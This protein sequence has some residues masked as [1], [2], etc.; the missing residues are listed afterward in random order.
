VPVRALQLEE[1]DYEDSGIFIASTLAAGCT[2]CGPS[3]S[4]GLHGG[5]R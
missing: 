2:A 5:G 1:I 3:G 4:G